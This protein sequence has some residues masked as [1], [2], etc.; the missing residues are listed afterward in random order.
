MARSVLD[1]PRLGL[2]L[3][4]PAGCGAE[5]AIK[6]LAN[7]PFTE[8]ARIRLF[9]DLPL[10][11]ETCAKLHNIP[12]PSFTVLGS[13]E[14]LAA[15]EAQH[16]HA[17]AHYLVADPAIALREAVPLKQATAAGGD[18]VLRTLT[19]AVEAHRRGLIEGLVFMPLNK[20]SMHLGGLEHQ[21]ELHWF[22]EALGLDDYFCEI[23]VLPPGDP[24]CPSGMWT[25]RVTSHIALSEVPELVT[26]QRIKDACRLAHR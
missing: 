12:T 14:E 8:R 21:D 11:E 20:Q 25:T 19:M 13:L 4:D 7:T 18:L 24:S 10:F 1:L 2:T 23:N 16:P 3:G 5:L 17:E 22:A 26:A 15:V 9:C 6:L